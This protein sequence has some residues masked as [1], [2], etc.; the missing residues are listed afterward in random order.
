MIDRASFYRKLSEKQ[1]NTGI[2]LIFADL[3]GTDW[4]ASADMTEYSGVI[5][6]HDNKN[7]AVWKIQS[8]LDYAKIPEPKALVAQNKGIEDIFFP[9]GCTYTDTQYFIG[10]F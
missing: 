8:K 4:R 9:K 1:N 3:E 7:N 5:V 6:T 10:H 2:T